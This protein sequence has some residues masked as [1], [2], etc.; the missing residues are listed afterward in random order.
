ML[1]PPEG[2]AA[3]SV[4]VHVSLPVP[5]GEELVQERALTP[6]VPVSVTPVPDVPVTVSVSA[7][8]A[9]VHPDRASIRKKDRMING[10]MSQRLRRQI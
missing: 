5:L 3:V 6:A 4:T 10:E 8:F 1:S 7:V 2:A 9:A